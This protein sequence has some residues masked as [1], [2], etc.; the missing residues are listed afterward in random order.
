[1]KNS[2]IF[3]LL[4]WFVC[5]ESEIQVDRQAVFYFPTPRAVCILYVMLH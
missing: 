4:H 5:F 1:M 2:D 3:P